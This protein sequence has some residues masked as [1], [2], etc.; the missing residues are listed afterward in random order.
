MRLLNTRTLRL[1]TFDDPTFTPAYAILSHTW[2]GGEVLFEDV[3]RKP[4]VMWGNKIGAVK[5]KASCSRALHDGFDYIWID[6]CCIDKS[7]SS[8]LSEAINSMFK[9]YEAA[10]VCYAYLGD[11]IDSFEDCKWF[12][13]GWTLQ[14]L[15]APKF[16]QFLN[17]DW[18]V[19]GT[20]DSKALDISLITGIDT[21]LLRRTSNIR[22]ALDSFS[23]ATRF[24]WA[25]ER[26]TSKEEDKAYCLMGMFDVTMPLLYG[27]GSRAFQRLQ[28]EIL[29]N[30]SDNSILAFTGPT[31]EG[32]LVTNPAQFTRDLPFTN[33][34][35]TGSKI[36]VDGDELSIEGLF[37]AVDTEG[38]LDKSIYM[39]GLNCRFADSLSIATV[40]LQAESESEP[41]PSRFKR[42]AFGI[43]RL[44]PGQKYLTLDESSRPTCYVPLTKSARLQRVVITHSQT[45]KD[46]SF[47]R[48]LKLRSLKQDKTLDFSLSHAV[49]LNSCSE[50][51]EP[52]NDSSRLRGTFGGLAAFVGSADRC[53]LLDW[54]STE[55]PE[56]PVG[57]VVRKNWCSVRSLKDSV[58]ISL[59][60]KPGETSLPPVNES[61]HRI[62]GGYDPLFS[63]IL[64]LEV[65]PSFM[66]GEAI[67]DGEISVA[68]KL[69]HEHFL[70]HVLFHL[71]VEI[72]T[73]AMAQ[74]GTE[75]R[76]QP[77]E[78]LMDADES[79]DWC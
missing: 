58:I 62:F 53:F 19:L 76:C 41:H 51:A 32:I 56:T 54:G 8:E 22:D 52:E 66:D 26:N 77:E 70:G 17:R 67:I 10:A 49:D 4:I 20:R 3:A 69:S 12:T 16:V 11:A 59:I 44:H 43:L 1:R 45:R 47:S 14:E 24:F 42:R 65:S 36:K 21:K 25:S 31:V 48:L 71:D 68:A 55:I 18:H 15:L 23:I 7:S 75:S 50:V 33:L 79:I 38:S 9:W 5:V 6:T 61:L 64:D 60:K 13:R 57:P 2:E 30:S 46:K 29:K 37:C 73:S 78:V 34:A 72:W 63:E 74:G 35:G 27:E 39:L 28:L 40:L